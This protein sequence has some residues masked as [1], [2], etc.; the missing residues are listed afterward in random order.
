MTNQKHRCHFVNL[1]R[2]VQFAYL[3]R[4]GSACVHTC[5]SALLVFTLPRALVH[6]HHLL[7]T[8]LIISQFVFK[9]FIKYSI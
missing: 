6:T 8:T 7:L 9:F 1:S 2:T 5:L 4:T 3:Y